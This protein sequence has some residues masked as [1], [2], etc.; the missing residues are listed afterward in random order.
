MKYFVKYGLILPMA[1]LTVIAFATAVLNKNIVDGQTPAHD[2]WKSKGEQIYIEKGCVGCHGVAG[3]GASAPRLAGLNAEYIVVQLEDFQSGLRSNPIM[4]MMA[5]QV[6]GL[7]K[8]IAAYLS[9]RPTL[10]EY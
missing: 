7:E 5:L 8:I 6:K 9:S 3:V 4:N 10:E 1:T 2:G